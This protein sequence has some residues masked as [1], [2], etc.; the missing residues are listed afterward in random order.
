MFLGSFTKDMQWWRQ[1]PKGEAKFVVLK[2]PTA[3]INDSHR[4]LK[5]MKV[6]LE[7]TI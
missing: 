4:V 1:G 6:L 7:L 3:V 5:E 2:V